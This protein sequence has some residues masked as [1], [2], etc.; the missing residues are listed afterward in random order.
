[1]DW[2]QDEDRPPSR[3]GIVTCLRCNLPFPS[4]DR[5]RTRICKK[6]NK[7]NDQLGRA[8]RLGG[9]RTTVDAPEGEAEP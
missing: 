7:A 6:C 1:L 8:A 3:G 2:S 4:P 9:F 5:A